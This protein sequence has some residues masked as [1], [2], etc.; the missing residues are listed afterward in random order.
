VSQKY[1]K[2]KKLTEKE[3]FDSLVT[4]AIEFLD[5]S[6]DNLNK[7]PKNSLV[8][9]YTSIELF[10][11]A[12]LMNEHWTLIISKPEN[13]NLNNFQNG[14]FHSIFLEDSI[15]RLKNILNEPLSDKIIENFRS[16]AEHRN[17]IV[18]FSHTDYSNATKISIV[19]EQWSSWHYL[20]QLLINK[21]KNIFKNHLQE[22][23]RINKRMLAE[24]EFIKAKYEELKPEIQKKI[25]GGAQ[26]VG[27]HHCKMDS[28]VIGDFHKWG[29]DYDCMVCGTKDTFIKAVQDVIA[30]QK[31]GHDFEFFQK[32]LTNCPHCHCNIETN[33]LIDECEKIYLEGDDWW[34]EGSPNVAFCHECNLERPSVFYIDGLWSCVSCF[35]RGWQAINCQGCNEFIIGDIDLIEAIGCHKCRE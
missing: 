24:I 2:Q 14:D 11:K 33:M 18:H 22:I 13:A 21:W 3:M 17:Q 25:K 30:C 34:E 19:A 5:T 10:L 6:L 29:I 27:C 16:L 12:R 7:K 31:C 23:S 8:D 35:D 32:G 9:F 1:I 20:H 28:A 15:K 4:N 26:V